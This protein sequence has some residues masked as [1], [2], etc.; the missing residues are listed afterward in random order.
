MDMVKLFHLFV[1]LFGFS[2]ACGVVVWQVRA[3][4]QEVCKVKK[5]LDTIQL[6]TSGVSLYILRGECEK[7]RED[8]AKDRCKEMGLLERKV[9]VIHR[10]MV[11]MNNFARWFLMSKEGKDLEEVERI[12]GEINPLPG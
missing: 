10:S 4:R 3:L 2:S 6:G 5:T 1:I 7:F 8:C 11:V 12:L 9:A